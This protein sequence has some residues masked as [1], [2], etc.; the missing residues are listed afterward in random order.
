MLSEGGE[1]VRLADFGLAI[2]LH[3][4]DLCSSGTEVCC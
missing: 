2:H 4:D 1:L 3:E